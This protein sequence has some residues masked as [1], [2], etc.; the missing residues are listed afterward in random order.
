MKYKR[1]YK[2]TIWTNHALERAKG[3]RVPQEI[4]WKA[5]KSPDT[6]I[7]GKK[8]QTFEFKKTIDKYTVTV[9]VKRNEK[10]EWIILSGWIDP[11]LEGSID[12]AKKGKKDDV[13]IWLY[14]KI[15]NLFL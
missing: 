7:A 1:I 12:L 13:L 15:K 2:G 9:I 14:K 6:K 5:F 4:L 8:P 11:P 10:R 3:R